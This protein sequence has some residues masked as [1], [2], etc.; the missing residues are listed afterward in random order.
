MFTK[1]RDFQ[2]WLST[3]ETTGEEGGKTAGA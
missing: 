1:D 3:Q 2:T